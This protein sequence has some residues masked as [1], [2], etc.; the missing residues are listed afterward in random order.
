[1]RPQAQA[2]GALR[3]AAARGARP[4][5]AR[6]AR[7]HSLSTALQLVGTGDARS[8]RHRVLTRRPGGLPGHGD[9]RRP[10]QPL[11][12]G[13]VGRPAL[14]RHRRLDPAGDG[15]QPGGDPREPRPRDP[16]ALQGLRQGAGSHVHGSR[17]REHP[18]GLALRDGRRHLP[19]EPDLRRAALDRGGGH[20]DHHDLGRHA[21]RDRL[22]R[23][24]QD[25][26]RS[27]SEKGG[28]SMDL[29]VVLAF[30]SAALLAS[31]RRPA[32]HP[33]RPVRRRL[34]RLADGTTAPI[35][36]LQRERRGLARQRVANRQLVRASSSRSLAPGG[37]GHEDSRTSTANRK[38]L[39][40]AGYR[41]ESARRHLHGKPR[42]AGTRHAAARS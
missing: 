42:R 33:S 20:H 24:P 14:L 41:H 2:H 32:S 37:E 39:M 12:P 28:N 1:M 25:G 40:E 18:G 22:L 7:G 26:D 29:F 4:A 9:A 13:G 34:A 38:R 21:H 27:R 3:A 19:R 8:H 11:V 23:L 6:A 35:H 17:L 36:D 15:Q 5:G 31:G 10:R 16:R 30:A